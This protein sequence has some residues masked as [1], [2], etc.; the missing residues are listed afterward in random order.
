MADNYSDR[1]QR[2]KWLT[3][4]RTADDE[5]DSVLKR[6]WD[7]ASDCPEE[8]TLLALNNV[9]DI[10]NPQKVKK[11]WYSRTGWMFAMAAVVLLIPVVSVV[12]AI[13]YGKGLDSD[14]EQVQCTVPVGAMQRMTLPDGTYVTLNAGSYLSYPQAFRGSE[15]IVRM[16]GEASFDVA[17]DEEHPFV[18]HTPKFSVRALGTRFSVLCDQGLDRSTATLE[19]GKVQISSLVDPEKVFFLNP[20]EQFS[21][22]T[23]LKTYHVS[24]VNAARENDWTT[25]AMY[26]NEDSLNEILE[27]A[28]RMYGRTI[29]N[30]VSDDDSKYTMSFPPGEDFDRIMDIICMTVGNIKLIRQEG[31]VIVTLK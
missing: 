18:V 28:G 13:R 6:I 4:D 1:T 15:R 23:R 30:L 20:D 22:D 31:S 14:Y 26:F 24:R 8:D 21:Y 7:L 9:L 19:E 10:I 12:S 16:V 29:V 25:G 17:H 2:L 27:K 5:M 3:D 11:R